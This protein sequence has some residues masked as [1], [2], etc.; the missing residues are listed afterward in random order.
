MNTTTQEA[1]ELAT[2]M[3]GPLV[4]HSTVERVVCPPYVSLSVVAELL[5]DTSV[6]VGAQDMHY[7]ASGAFTGEISPVMLQG[8]C[9]Y[10]ILGHSETPGAFRL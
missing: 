8:L 2:A 1:A 6:A 10:V 7:E 5:R 3:A 9:Q 4:T